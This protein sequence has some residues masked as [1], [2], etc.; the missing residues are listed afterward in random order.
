MKFKEYTEG[1][2]RTYVVT[3]SAA[4]RTCN[5]A[6]GLGGECGEVLELVKK[7]K[8]HGHGIDTDAMRNEL[9]DVL[10]YLTALADTIGLD[11]ADVAQA[12]LDKLRAR[13]P[14]GFDPERSKNHGG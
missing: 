4:E 11:L 3:Q 12:N 2:R 6:L 9:G 13:Y 8:F 5:F 7:G 10:W 14:D 1:V